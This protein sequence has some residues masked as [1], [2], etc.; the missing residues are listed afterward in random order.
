MRVWW[1]VRFYF[2]QPNDVLYAEPLPQRS[3]GIGITGAQ[4]LNTIVSTLSTSAAL[5]FV[6]HLIE[7]T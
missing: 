2:I 4:T 1:A 3:W 7:P 6:H 5:D